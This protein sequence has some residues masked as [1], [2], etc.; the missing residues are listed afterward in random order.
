MFQYR[1]KPTSDYILLEGWYRNHSIMRVWNTLSNLG[2][3]FE[4]EEVEEFMAALDKVK[5]HNELR[6]RCMNEI[7]ARAN[8]LPW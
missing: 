1:I 7:I 8:A 5:H 4:I 3:R 6:E 2:F